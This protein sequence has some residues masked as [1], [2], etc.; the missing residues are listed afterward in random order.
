MDKVKI[1]TILEDS[2]SVWDELTASQQKECVDHSV[3][4]HYDAQSNIH[5]RL[6]G[7]AG[8]I[9]VQQ[10]ELRTY[11]LS[12]EGKEITLFRSYEGD[13]CILSA[14]CALSM[15]DFEVFVDAETD[16][17]VLVLSS[18]CFS[19]ISKENIHLEC[20][21]YRVTTERFS[22]VMWVMQQI[23]F[24]SIDERLA[25]FLLDESNKLKSESLV[26]T[27]EQIAKYIGSAR[28]V[29]SRMLKYFEKE[30]I[31][32]IF[33]GGVEIKNKQKLKNIIKK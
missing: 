9:F 30:G 4:I 29:V 31:V 11:I 26:I 20:F 24:M 18:S 6:Q 10:G 25:I 21:A 3:L 7:C 13:C 33:R 12:S 15:I 27:H 16:A 1:R 32:T 8:V 14:S 5:G 22:D 19:K 17:Y 23:L 28:E 2:I